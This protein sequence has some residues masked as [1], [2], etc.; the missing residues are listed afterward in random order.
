MNIKAHILLICLSAIVQTSAFAG[1]KYWVGGSGNWSDS[2]H[3]AAVS[4]G[5]GGSGLPSL[6]DNVIIDDNSFSVSGNI[7]CEGNLV[8][9]SFALNTR[10]KSVRLTGG[11]TAFFVVKE[12]FAVGKNNINNF[13]GAAY[14]LNGDSNSKSQRIEAGDFV[15]I[16]SNNYVRSINSDE[17]LA[18]TSLTTVPTDQTCAGNCDGAITATVIGGGPFFYEWFLGA[19]PYASGNGMNV[20]PGLC[21]GQ[22]LLIVTDQADGD[23]QGV[24]NI[25]VGPT[26]GVSLSAKDV[27]CIGDTDGSVSAFIIGGAAPL[28]YSWNSGQTSKN[29]AGVP[30]GNYILTVTDVNLCTTSNT[31][32]VDEPPPIVIAPAAS[33]IPLCG[34][35]GCT[36]D[37]AFTA[38][39]GNGGPFGIV[40]INGTTL[41]PPANLLNICPGDAFEVEATDS[42]GCTQTLIHTATI[43]PPLT[44]TVTMT[45]PVTCTGVDDGEATA[46]AAGGSG[47]YTFD[48]YDVVGT[49]STPAVT[50]LPNGTFHVAVTDQGTGCIDTGLVVITSPTP[51]V[52]IA[53][54]SS[55]SPVICVGLPTGDA[56]A[57]G[58]G[59]TLPHTYI[60]LNIAGNPTTQMV[61]NLNVGMY[62]VEVTD[63]DGCK[64]TATVDIQ[65]PNPPVITTTLA[66]VVQPTC[67]LQCDGSGTATAAGGRGPYD[68]T[69]FEL[70][71]LPTTQAVS[72]LCP[73]AYRVAVE[74]QDGCKDTVT[75]AL[76]LPP[77][78]AALASKVDVDCNGQCTGEMTATASGG[79]PVY[80]YT[81]YDLVGTPT[82][83]VQNAICAGTYNVQVSDALGCLD[84]LQVDINENPLINI[85]VDRQ[86]NNTCVTN[87]Q[88][89]LDISFGGGVPALTYLFLDSNGIAPVNNKLQNMIGL[90][91]GTYTFEVTDALNCVVTNPVSI[92]SPTLSVA[93]T[94]SPL[95]PSSTVANVQALASG[96]VAP[97][98]YTWLD[99]VTGLVTNRFQV[100]LSPGSYDLQV[101]DAIGCTGVFTF[102]FAIP[103]P[104]VGTPITTDALCKGV[105]DGTIDATITGGTA[106]YNVSWYDMA[107]TPNTDTVINV[108]AGTYNMAIEDAFGCLDTM[109][110]LT[111][112]PQVVLNI[113]PTVVEALCQGTCDG[114]AWVT[115]SNG[116]LPYQ[117][118]WYDDPALSTTDTSFNVCVGNFNV[119]VSDAQGCIDTL[120]IAMTAKPSV[121]A[122]IT[123]QV[124]NI[125][126]QD[127]S[128]QATVGI[129]G[130][131]APFDISWT[132][133]P[134]TPITPA[135]TGLCN[136][137]YTVRVTDA[138][139][140]FDEAIAVI[141]SSAAVPNFTIGSPS[142]GGYSDGSITA[143]IIG[144]NG[145][146][147]STWLNIPGQPTS[148]F[149]SGLG[150]GTYDLEIRDGAG[151]IDTFPAIITDPF[152]PIALTT[153]FTP[154]TCFGL[155]DGKAWAT[156]TA[157]GTYSYDW[158]NDPLGSV[159]DTART[160]CVGTYDIAVQDLVTGCR[161][162]TAVTVTNPFNIDVLT[163]SKPPCFGVCDGTITAHVQGI[164]QPYS[165]AWN[166]GPPA[167]LD[168]TVANLCAGTYKVKVTNSTGC[169]DS[170]SAT[171]TENPQIFTT[172]D[173][174]NSLCT[175]TTNGTAAYIV[176]GGTQ[177]FKYNWTNSGAYTSL[178]PN[179]VNLGPGKYYVTATDFVGCA[180][181]DSVDM[182]STYFIDADLGADKSICDG[183]SITLKATGG[184]TYEWGDGS[185]EDSLLVSPSFTT[186]YTV[187]TTNGPCTDQD[188]VKVSVSGLP[189]VS[190]TALQNVILEG[191]STQLLGDG[192]GTN[193][194]YDWSP[195]TDISDPTTQ[196]PI[197]DPL[198]DT[199]YHLT[200][201]TPAGCIDTTSV[202]IQVIESILYPDGFS[203]NGD[204]INDDWPIVY[205][206]NFPQATVEIYNRWGQLLFN[207]VGYSTRWDGKY[208]GK[209]LPVGTYYFIID[210][211]VDF[212]KY[213]GP[214]TI[215][216]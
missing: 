139:L 209:D 79:T 208:N 84:T 27:T 137:S 91:N 135:V 175:N 5:A 26:F 75:L 99:P 166:D 49:P 131:Q 32:D 201:T 15:G 213:T 47:L 16:I 180:V 30:A 51:K 106:P 57:L 190:A 111:V 13:L 162:S 23:I 206:E 216:R 165:Y 130:G 41:L 66:P 186:T 127:C 159:T 187:A 2:E 64:D 160:L 120:P 63:D 188:D 62:D 178:V 82:G 94:I 147:T 44:V 92:V 150:A 24:N 93:F 109:K 145:G 71:G 38:T 170:A 77:V 19:V 142:C 74:D 45:K 138:N 83:P 31:R 46:S 199:R 22:Y 59:G 34:N 17:A 33:D 144:G 14:F 48:W 60:W 7:S 72:N 193:G 149:V 81:W 9:K 103:N 211:G 116:L 67:G 152:P 110:N 85:N 70:P 189:D 118:S 101:V 194:T 134:G 153:D 96:G 18:I 177:P 151:C 54:I 141:S 176:T 205:I 196:N 97:Y 148:N 35:T 4:G 114:K 210:L 207:S 87:C 78:T 43:P 174:T 36:E 61:S 179:P 95:C 214:I 3:W 143:N 42:K 182:H 53:S 112:N 119:K 133:V 107:G 125:C 129:T 154:V 21:T 56:T 204:G 198:V 192:A 88:G 76:N 155:C 173:T 121:T 6:E 20:L 164:G 197:I 171:I 10:S 161:D 50:G 90:C 117:Y 86:V 195:P 183:Q 184:V 167:T 69:W 115:V 65:A 80:T 215:F 203:P 102:S 52:V 39:G 123:S 191:K 1:A 202:L 168:S 158:K 68:Y 200:V 169:I 29:I 105:C 126:S 181:S 108:C 124:N 122:A 128:G 146:E 100:G 98:D 113:A 28:Q 12:A 73:G 163:T 11:A 58:T 136:G 37:V 104:I 156:P 212:P 157:A 185:V 172:L 132:N 40:G 140:C 55:F 25:N 89:E 8:M